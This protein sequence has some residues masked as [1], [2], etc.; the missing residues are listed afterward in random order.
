MTRPAMIAAAAGSIARV[1]V[2]SPLPQLDHLFDYAVPP[3]LTG[4]ARPGVRVRVPL[5]MAGRIADGYLVALTDESAAPGRLSAL[6]AV[7]SPVPVLTDDVWRLA[8]AVADRA[9][10][11]ASDVLR[12]AVPKRQVRVERA[13]LAAGEAAGAPAEVDA[14]ADPPAEVDAPIRPS[15]RV[16]APPVVA[17]LLQG[18]RIAAEATPRPADLPSGPVGAWAVE[19]ARVAAG[20]IAGGR[21]AIVAVPD[22][23]D[24]DQVAAALAAGSAAAHVVRVD[25]A[26]SSAARY[27]AH[28]TALRPGPR[29]LLGNR[30]AVYAPAPDLGAILVWEE[31]DPFHR[32]PL[33]PY[34]GTRDVALLRQEQSGAGLLLLAHARSTTVERLVQV[35]WVAGSPSPA[36]APRV[37][38]TPD[39][40]RASR[41]PSAAWRDV[42]RALT[43]GPVLVQVARPGDAAL[44]ALQQQEHAPPSERQDHPA[45]AAAL[46]VPPVDAGRT[47]HDLGRAFPGVPVVVADGDHPHPTVPHEPAIVVATRGAE[48]R[49]AAGYRAVLLLDGRRMLARESL[50]VAEDCLRWWS[51]AAA[52]AAPDAPVHLVGVQGD[53][54]LALATWRSP[55][56]AAAQLADRRSLRFPPVTRL[57]L[58]TGSRPIVEELVAELRSAGAD[59]LIREDDADGGPRVVMRFDYGAGPAVAAVAKAAVVR[60]AAVRRPPPGS[61]RR[62]AR[63]LRVRFDVHEPL[64]S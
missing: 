4:E 25:A 24:L 39:D 51:N 10:G 31:A 27:R 29:I 55:D 37:V 40:E 8:R 16:D 64:P 61:G 54:A 28:L 13:W 41:I 57:A 42:A 3:H 38:L 50:W 15:A 18:Q 17:R 62:P 19:L 63:T 22:Q 12:I 53:V 32:E 9:A 35:G 30:S 45:G 59:A 23:R 1:V 21:T 46:V 7:V 6:D 26:Q 56:F 14:P 49:T 44:R 33:A 47:A 52:L 5:R 58:L 60:A 34:A 2:D 43:N 48:P 20:V 36:T 11:V